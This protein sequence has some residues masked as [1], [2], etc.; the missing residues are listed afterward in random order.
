M[1]AFIPEISGNKEEEGAFPSAWPP[2]MTQCLMKALYWQYLAH[3]QRGQ[4]EIEVFFF[5]GEENKEQ[6]A[7]T[8]ATDLPL[9]TSSISMETE[10]RTGKRKAFLE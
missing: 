6:Y 8:V 7:T 3:W 4:I 10:N 9:V 2:F 5:H 1:G